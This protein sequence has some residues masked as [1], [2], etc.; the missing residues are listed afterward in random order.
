[1]HNQTHIQIEGKVAEIIDDE[2]SRYVTIV[3]AANNFMVSLHI[4]EDVSLGDT[5]VLDGELIL[6]KISVNGI[7][8]ETNKN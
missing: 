1:M 8:I 7:E 6:D 3:S 2:S 5:I 4:T